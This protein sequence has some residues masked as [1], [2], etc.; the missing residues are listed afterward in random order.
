M[1]KPTEETKQQVQTLTQALLDQLKIQGTVTVDVDETDAYR[2]HVLTEETGILIGHH[3]KT[4]ESFQVILS[5]IV[6]KELGQAKVYVNV[7][8][9]RER[10][11][12]S[13]MYLA[14]RAAERAIETGRAVELTHLSPSERRVVHLTLSGDERIETESEGEGD[15]RVLVVKPKAII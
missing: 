2:V 5:L 7:N 9:Y 1:E 6:A 3:G 4:L 13:L 10:R 15:R 14:Q 11:E 8:D 12:E